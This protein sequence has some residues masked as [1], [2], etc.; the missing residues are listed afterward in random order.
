MAGGD[1]EVRPEEQAPLAEAVRERLRKFV[2]DEFISRAGFARDVATGITNAV[3]DR[4]HET[5][6]VLHDKDGARRFGSRVI[7]A[8]ES[9]VTCARA[10]A[11]CQG[12][13]AWWQGAGGYCLTLLEQGKAGEAEAQQAELLAGPSDFDMHFNWPDYKLFRAGS[14]LDLVVGRELIGGDGEGES[15]EVAHR[16]A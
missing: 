3:V 8:A 11:L 9:A 1:F 16:G 7:G 15:R 2:H 12:E 10:T 5:D 14:N 4:A 6:L 13:A